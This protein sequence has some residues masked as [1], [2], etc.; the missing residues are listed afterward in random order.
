[1]GAVAAYREAAEGRAGAARAGLE[2][3]V[4][5]LGALAERLG[6]GGQTPQE[7]RAAL[8]E[9]VSR[10]SVEGLQ[11]NEP[12]AEAL[13]EVQ[14]LL[15]LMVRYLRDVEL[16]AQLQVPPVSDGNNFGVD[17]QASCIALVQDRRQK[18]R[19]A[20]ETLSEWHWQ[21]GNAIEK[22][23]SQTVQVAPQAGSAPG[24][25]PTRKT[26]DYVEDFRMFV[27]SL[28]VKA[29]FDA[30]DSCNRAMADIVVCLDTLEKN[31]EKVEQP[32]GSGGN[33]TLMY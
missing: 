7:A 1:M 21:R 19:L 11:A 33:V 14:D 16:W 23:A 18:A 29:Q 6:G 9:R 2:A 22:F 32:R 17:V 25:G 24:P 30:Y 5:D 28:D 27:V 15:T 4:G 20:F 31:R 26:Y 13:G 10:A 3:L 12:L 8:L